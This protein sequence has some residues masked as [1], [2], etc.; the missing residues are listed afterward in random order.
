MK[1]KRV[2][3]YVRVSTDAQTTDNQLQEIRSVAARAGW[4]I[5]HEFV[6]RGVSGA[7]GRDQRPAFDRM[8]KAAARREFDLIAAWSVDR[9]GRSLQHLISL[10]EEIHARKIDLE[11]LRARKY[12]AH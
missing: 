4:Q 6:D 10:L 7:K 2:A 12:T 1:A 8:L 5:V 3:V 9:L 11:Q